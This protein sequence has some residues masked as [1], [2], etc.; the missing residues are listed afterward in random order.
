MSFS[1]K[2]PEADRIS[3]YETSGEIFSKVHIFKKAI[4]LY[5]LINHRFCLRECDIHMLL[6]EV[7]SDLEALAQQ[8]GIVIRIYS[9]ISV[10]VFSSP[11]LLRLIFYNLLETAIFYSK[12]DPHYAYIEVDCSL[13]NDQLKIIVE[14][15]GIGIE[16]VEPLVQEE[17]NTCSQKVLGLALVRKALELMHGT[18]QV[19][20]I[21]GCYTKM[22]VTLNFT[23]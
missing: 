1:Q 8:R 6:D 20:S 10:K 13:V 22:S 12:P 7:I 15:N 23:D 19:E 2:E 11:E 16:A 9:D 5:N 17:K 21:A 3:Y 18:I 4:A 14:D